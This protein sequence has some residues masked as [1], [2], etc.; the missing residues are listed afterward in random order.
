MIKIENIKNLNINITWRL[1]YIAL[2][3]G[4]I[5]AEDIIEFA[6]DILVQ[7]DN[8][9]DICELAGADSTDLEYIKEILFELVE[10]ENSDNDF[11][12]RKIRAVIVS[13]KLKEKNNNYINGL[14]ELTELWV[15]FGYP[16]D[17]PH[18]IQGRGNNITPSEYYTQSNYDI[19]YEKNRE[20]V[21]KELSFLKNK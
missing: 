4:M 20:W 10:D 21:E 9:L 14:M 8:R 12:E 1:L 16:E 19:L 2:Q 3:E 13:E 17:S 11:E 6:A 7:G 15:K 5:S 18:T